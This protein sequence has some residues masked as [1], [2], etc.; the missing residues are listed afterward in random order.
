MGS[1]E[2][3]NDVFQRKGIE[4]QLGMLLKGMNGLMDPS[5]WI[6]KCAIRQ[7]CGTLKLVGVDKER[8]KPT[9][10]PTVTLFGFIALRLSP[11]IQYSVDGTFC[12]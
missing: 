10:N 8:L 7:K 11:R 9:I 1:N 2:Y 5:R 6:G 4:C 3:S 12:S